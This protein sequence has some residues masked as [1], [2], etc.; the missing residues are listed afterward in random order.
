M[1]RILLAF[2]SF[3]GCLTSAEVAEAV[4]QGLR[5]SCPDAELTLLTMSDGGDGMLDA[6]AAAM[7]ARIETLAVHDPLMRP[8]QARMGRTDDGNTVIIEM[9]EASG[10]HLLSPDERH[11]LATSSFGTG[12]LIAEA[13]RRGC[14]KIVVGL[15]GSA[16]SDAGIGMLQA[17]GMKIRHD[18]SS[19]S[20]EREPH[21]D[22]SEL[23]PTLRTTEFVIA[24]DV[25]NPLL[26]S[27]GAAHVFAPQKGATPAE[28][29]ELERRARQFAEA[30][31]AFTGCDYASVTGAGAAGGV[32]FALM[33]FVNSHMVSGAE[34]L[35]EQL[36]FDSLLDRADWVLTGEGS[37]DR[38]TLMGKLPQVVLQH[39]QRKSVPVILCSGQ[40]HGADALRSA[41]FAD[42]QSFNPPDL[43]LSD[44]VRPEVARQQLFRHFSAFRLPQ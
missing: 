44:A 15:G 34:L 35:L 3:K 23:S 41:G 1:P 22:F 16:T 24:C 18:S 7:H 33:A 28:V 42:V 39:A 20:N 21:F 2:D 30:V 36:R 13:L 40:L 8:V 19:P 10:L 32:G 38:Q 27:S 6:F 11:P 43:P 9:A 17:L 4:A 31:A 5:R 29:E 25:T 26:G 37:S 12:E 14:G